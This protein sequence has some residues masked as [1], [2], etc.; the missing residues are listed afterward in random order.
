MKPDIRRFLSSM[1]HF[2]FLTKADL[3]RVVNQSVI[4]HLQSGHPVAVQGQ[5]R[6]QNVLV[7]MK[8]Q[9]SLYQESQ[10]HRELTGYIKKGEV[11]GGISVMLNAGVCLRTTTAD[12]QVDAISIPDSVIMETCA[13][14]KAF[15]E[16]FLAHFSRNIFDASLDELAQAGQARLFLSG[17]NP[18]TFLPEEDIDVAAES[19]A[20]VS[21]PKGTVLFVQA[22]TRVGY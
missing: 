1:P 3:D 18:F 16:Y 8:G 9:L 6:I 15:Y 10:G 5:T 7:V 4:V 17:V 21:Y 13:T 11:F 12:T 19:L 2:S 22:K 20:R 14:N